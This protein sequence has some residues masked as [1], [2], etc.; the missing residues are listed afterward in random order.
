MPSQFDIPQPFLFTL[1]RSF[2]KPCRRSTGAFFSFNEASRSLK[3]VP[4]TSGDPDRPEC[5]LEDD[6]VIC[7]A[8]LSTRM[9]IFPLARSI[10]HR[11]PLNNEFYT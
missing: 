2:P 8:Q 4:T 1:L 5:H 7:N 11:L 6:V 3:S 9:N 10:L